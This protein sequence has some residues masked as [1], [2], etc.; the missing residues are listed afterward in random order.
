MKS[1]RSSVSLIMESTL[2]QAIERLTSEY[3]EEH[4]IRSSV[5]TGMRCEMARHVA[6]LMRWSVH[7]VWSS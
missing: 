7:A 3:H 6:T 4:A 2:S 1:R 5:V